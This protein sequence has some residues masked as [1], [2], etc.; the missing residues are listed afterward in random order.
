MDS[1]GELPR[2]AGGLLPAVLGELGSG[3]YLH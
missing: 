3:A 1:V 2:L